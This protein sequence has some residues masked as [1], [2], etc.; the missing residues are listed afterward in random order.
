M[1]SRRQFSHYMLGIGFV[2]FGAASLTSALAQD[3][4][5]RP[6]TLLVGF[7]AGGPTDSA[8]R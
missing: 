4:P 3:Y 6:I 8:A 5:T 1:I 7:S 2:L